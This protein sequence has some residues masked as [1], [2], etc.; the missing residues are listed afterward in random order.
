MSALRSLDGDELQ[1]TLARAASHL[2][3]FSRVADAVRG[4]ES[5]GDVRQVIVSTNKGEIVVLGEDY[6]FVA[7]R[8]VA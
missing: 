2:S 5:R 6:S 3:L 4:L 8:V 7:L 1:P